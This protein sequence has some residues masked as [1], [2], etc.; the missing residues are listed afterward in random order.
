MHIA[1]DT[2]GTMADVKLQAK[3]SI[4][5]ASPRLYTATVVETIW[6]ELRN[7]AEKP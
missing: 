6:K 3:A 1:S 4:V 5:I 2:N 7:P